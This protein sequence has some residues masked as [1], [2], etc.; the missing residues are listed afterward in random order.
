MPW[1]EKEQEEMKKISYVSAVDS[2]MCVMMCTRLDIAHV[3]DNLD[4]DNWDVVKWILW[5][6]RGTCRVSLKLGDN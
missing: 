2:L 5:F 1:S 6:L 4:K 3:V